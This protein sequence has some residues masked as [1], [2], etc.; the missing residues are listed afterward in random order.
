[1]IEY[2]MKV[3]LFGNTSSPAVATYGLRK[4]ARV[5]ETQF[6]YDAREFVERNFYVDDGVKSLP[7]IAESVDL[8]QRTQ[9]MLA[10][11][12]LRL[13]KIAS[14][15]PNVTNAFPTNDRASELCDLDLSKDVKPIQRSMGVYWDLESD[16]FTFKVS[17]GDKPFTKRGVLSVIN[18]LFDPLGIVAP[19][20]IKGKMLLRVM[21]THLK[22]RQLENW[23]QSLPDEHKATWEEWCRSLCSLEQLRV[24]RSYT[25]APLLE[26]AS[27][28]LHVF[29][30]ASTHGIAAVCYLKF[31]Q[32]DGDVKVSF[33]FGKAK[34]APLHATTIPRLEL[35]AAV[36]AVEIAELVVEEQAIKPC[37]ITDYSDSKVVLGYIANET[38][39]FYTYVANRVDCIR[40]SSSPEEWRYVPIHLNPADCTTRSVKANELESSAWLSGPKFLR[41]QDQSNS[42]LDNHAVPESLADDPKVRPEIKALNTNAQRST[43]LGST[44][45][46]RF[47]SWSR[48]VGGM[49]KLIVVARSYANRKEADD[50]P[51]QSAEGQPRLSILQGRQKAELVIFKNVQLEAFEKEIGRLKNGK[52]LSKGSPLSKLN[53]VIDQDGVVRVG[54]RLSRA[55]LTLEERHPIILPGS[56]H[57][58]QLIVKHY[59][60]EVKHQG[61]HFTHG[62]IRA[63][64]FWI[65]G[66]KRLVSSVIDHCVKC[67]KL[68]AQQVPQKMADLPTQRLTPAPPFTFVGVDVF[69]P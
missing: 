20:V 53:P 11:A 48:L 50:Q 44:R 45:L 6:G 22:N 15:D 46:M 42:T 24:P 34:L 47:S 38:R 5:E 8:L 37:C 56:H 40:K 41:D 63:K 2:R 14:N 57:I 54:G 21:A 67:R 49:S 25:R 69:G 55:E 51:N 32:T 9:A 64:G 61:R 4:T 7:G 13:H 28:E 68:R 58:T 62:L 59:H 29:C 39:R 31:I 17:D 19:V 27:V 66:G 16:T 30:D 33:V 1:M 3:H 36:L 12:N 18:S 65:V 60:H 10:T 26:A 52:R 35:C 43:A 23:D